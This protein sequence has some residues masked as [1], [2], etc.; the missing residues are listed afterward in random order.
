[1]KV[2]HFIGTIDRDSGGVATN[3]QLLASELKKFTNLLVVTS[4]CKNPIDLTGVKIR[5]LDLSLRRWFRLKKEF[6]DFLQHEKPDVVHIN[7]IW[8]PQNFIFQ[9]AA[10]SLN[11]KVVISPHGMLEPYILKR[12]SYKKKLALILYQ[13]KAITTADFL[14]TTAISE[15]EN[16]RKL[17]FK[18]PA[19]I[20]PNGLDLTEI[21]KKKPVEAES[22]FLNILFLSR[23]H[24]KKGIELLIE[25]VSRLKDKNFKVIVAG[26]GDQDYTEFLIKLTAT[27]EVDNKIRFLGG[28][29]G[30]DKWDLYEQANLFV[31]PTYSENFGIVIIEALA[32]GVPVITTKATP[33]QELETFNCGWWIDLNVVNLSNTLDHAIHTSREE[34]KS[35]GLRGRKL[36]EDKY[37]NKVLAKEMVK[38]YN[39]VLRS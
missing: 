16:I 18:K 23:I 28:V 20:I 6:R 11:I 22:P 21:K 1:M 14:L 39:E 12:N 26:E 25:S 4:R 38:F 19:G 15:L 30:Q 24:P 37:D 8:D 33:W 29:Y 13:R 34:L 7:G 27:K 10:K 17:G 32:A 9:Q 3:L 31:L 5:F 35:M 36:V 2:V